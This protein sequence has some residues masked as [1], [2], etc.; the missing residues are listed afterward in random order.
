M[1]KGHTVAEWRRRSPEGQAAGPCTQTFSVRAQ[2]K[3]HTVAVVHNFDRPPRTLGAQER[4]LETAGQVPG[5][6]TIRGSLA[7]SL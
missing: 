3:E 1:S 5:V 4:A 7:T 2:K 6:S